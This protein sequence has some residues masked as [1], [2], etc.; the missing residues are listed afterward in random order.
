MMAHGQYLVLQ[1]SADSVPARLI[2]NLE[3]AWPVFSTLSINA[4]N[5]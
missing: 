1:D 3:Q 4:P 5:W 2:P